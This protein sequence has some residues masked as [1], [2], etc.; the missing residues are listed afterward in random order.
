MLICTFA[1]PPTSP[2]PTSNPNCIRGSSNRTRSQRV[3]ICASR[4][5]NTQKG[6]TQGGVTSRVAH[7]TNDILRS[8]RDGSVLPGC[9][10]GLHAGLSAALPW[11]QNLVRSSAQEMQPGQL[12]LRRLAREET[13]GFPRSIGERA[14]LLVWLVDNGLVAVGHGRLH[15]TVF[16]PPPGDAR[17][18]GNAGGYF[19]PR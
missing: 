6:G 8:F 4:V 16:G 5:P 11:P 9:R 2:S 19:K 13:R 7:R 12:R 15:E 10:K 18:R 3:P 17:R 1:L 14:A